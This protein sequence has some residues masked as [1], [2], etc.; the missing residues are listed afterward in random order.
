MRLFAA[1]SSERNLSGGT[2]GGS[3]KSSLLT[4]DLAEA[5]EP[6][7]GQMNLC[8]GLGGRQRG[9]TVCQLLTVFISSSLQA[10]GYYLGKK[11]YI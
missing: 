6:V 11:P 7:Q 10:N 3:D 2:A 5:V 8:R 1:A 9:R 4:Q